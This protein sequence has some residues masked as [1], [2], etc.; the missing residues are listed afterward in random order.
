MPATAS[1]AK[2]ATAAAC[3]VN[4]E[5]TRRHLVPLRLNKRLSQAAAGHARDMVARDYF[6]HDTQ[7]G[8]NFVSRIVKTGYVAP[9]AFP[10][11]GEDLAWG[12][13][14]LGTAREILKGWMNSPGHRAN[15]LCRKFHEMGMGVAIG[16]PGGD[17]GM[18]GAT[19]ALDF[20]SGGRG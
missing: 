15:I 3:L 19:F 17:N 13:G 5:R 18:G 14:T 8:G 1:S 7:G 20:G 6:A 10:S 9:H 11:L 2:L 4:Q 12:S 16:V